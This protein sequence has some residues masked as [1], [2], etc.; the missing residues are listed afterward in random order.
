MCSFPILNS[1]CEN[2]CTLS[3]P[4]IQR[5]C[6]NF[7]H[8]FLWCIPQ[9]YVKM[10]RLSSTRSGATSRPG[11][12]W[13]LPQFKN[14]RLFSAGI[15]PKCLATKSSQHSICSSVVVPGGNRKADHTTI[16][17]TSGKNAYGQSFIRIWKSPWDERQR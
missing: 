9:Q 16:C 15:S 8:E 6:R 4:S 5:A 17:V 1:V 13:M 12:L 7:S 11:T 10:L 3:R 2:L 14:H